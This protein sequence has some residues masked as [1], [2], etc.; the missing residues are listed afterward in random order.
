VIIVRV[1]RESRVK[2]G[3]EARGRRSKSSTLEVDIDEADCE[4]QCRLATEVSAV[5]KLMRDLIRIDHRIARE[6][7][8][9]DM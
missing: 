8:K 3:I 4:R 2:W 6:I 9:R 7:D 1:A 5:V